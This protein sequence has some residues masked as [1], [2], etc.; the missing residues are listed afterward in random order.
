M[1]HRLVVLEWLYKA[2]QDFGFAKYSL[3]TTNY[4]DQICFFFQQAAEKYL[5][6][7][8]VKFNLN[9][10]K[11]HDLLK[12]LEI[13][14]RHDST[15][16]NLEENC[17]FLTPFYFES[18]YADNIFAICSKNQAENAF[19]HAEKVQSIIRRKLGIKEEI[20]A[21][22]IK[23]ENKKIDIILKKNSKIVRTS[24]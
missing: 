6:A 18:R 3:D 23:R 15:L 20:T 13:C 24:A 16:A 14:T 21:D 19:A 4:Y 17:R 11:L 12:L 10:K 1:V 8:I 5:K 9:F 22:E 7:Y 2:D